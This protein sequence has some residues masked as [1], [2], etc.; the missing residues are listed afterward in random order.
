MC[1]YE[2]GII[3]NSEIINGRGKKRT[4]SN[5]PLVDRFITRLL[6][7]KLARYFNPLFMEN[8]FAYQ[9]GKGVLEAVL[10]L[11]KKYLFC[12]ISTDGSVEDKQVG[13]VQ[14]NVI[15]PVLSN[16]YLNQ[17]DMVLEFGGYSWIRFADNVYIL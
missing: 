6:A 2:P 11:I 16:L 13:L 4:I 17:F 3:K 15:S 8:S 12:R 9:E 14:G 5:L 7:Q 10:H 1:I